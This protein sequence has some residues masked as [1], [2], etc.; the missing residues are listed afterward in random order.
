MPAVCIYK[1][2]IVIKYKAKVIIGH[3][4]KLKKKTN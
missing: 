2:I 3:Y 1:D 4:R